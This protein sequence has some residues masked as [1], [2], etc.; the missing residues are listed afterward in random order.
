MVGRDGWKGDVG[1]QAM[2]CL[3]TW[4]GSGEVR[5]EIWGFGSDILFLELRRSQIFSLLRK[6]KGKNECHVYVLTMI[7]IS[8]AYGVWWDNSNG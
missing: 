3:E 7:R 1:R 2:I 6:G 8:M 4:E 5:R